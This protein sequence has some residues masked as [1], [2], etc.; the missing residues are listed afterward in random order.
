[1]L[2]HAIQFPSLHSILPQ[3]WLTCNNPNDA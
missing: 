1:M 3:V 2:N